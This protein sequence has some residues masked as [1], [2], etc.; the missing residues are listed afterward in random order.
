MANN[1]HALIQFP[2]TRIG[3]TKSKTL[4]IKNDGVIPA[5]A[6]FE[7]TGHKSFKFMDQAT[8]TLSPK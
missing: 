8:F 6:K 7:L 3:K 1:T 4:V 5:T 2:K